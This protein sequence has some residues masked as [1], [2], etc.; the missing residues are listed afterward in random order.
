MQ[1][2]ISTV[3]ITQLFILK[4]LQ[5]IHTAEP[6]KQTLSRPK[7]IYITGPLGLALNQKRTK[8]AF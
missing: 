2:K 1:A 4:I 3:K 8:I 7:K 6:I 5:E